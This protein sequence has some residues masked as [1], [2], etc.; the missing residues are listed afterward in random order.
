MTLCKYILKFLLPGINH[1][2]VLLNGCSDFASI[3]CLPVGMFV[4]TKY[5]S[6]TDKNVMC[7]LNE[8]IG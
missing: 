1:I 2:T 8:I 4:L 6:H 7:M 5:C 3:E